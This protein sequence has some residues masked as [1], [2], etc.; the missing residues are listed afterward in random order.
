MFTLSLAE[1][2]LVAFF[3]NIGLGSI[4]YTQCEKVERN[5]VVSPLYVPLSIQVPS[6]PHLLSTDHFTICGAGEAKPLRSQFLKPDNFFGPKRDKA[7][8]SARNSQE[9]LKG[10][11]TRFIQLG[12]EFRMGVTYLLRQLRRLEILT[13]RDT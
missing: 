11:P 13:N 2:F 7:L 8:N 10:L 9:V 1:K 6:P 5:R 4:E 12:T 3:A